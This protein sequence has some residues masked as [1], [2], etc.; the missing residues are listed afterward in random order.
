MRRV[1]VMKTDPYL[2]ELYKDWPVL[3]VSDYGDITQEFLKLNNHLYE[4]AQEM[5]L[6]PLTLKGFFDSIVNKYAFG[7][8]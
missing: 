1:P 4:E 2:I 7:H 5:D 6:T 8:V 3:W